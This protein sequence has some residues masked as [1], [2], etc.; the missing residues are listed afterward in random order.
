MEYGVLG[1][2]EVRDGE[3]LIALGSSQ[4]RAVLA[5]LLLEANRPVSLDRLV[6][7]LWGEQPPRSA[8]AVV[9]N[10][11]S[12]LRK[13][14]AP[15]ELRTEPSGYLLRVE[16]DQLD[17]H[18]FEQLAREGREALTIGRS[19]WAATLLTQAL[20]LWRGPALADF[21]YEAFAQGEIARLEELRLGALEN[22]LDADLACGRAAELVP[23]L[24]ALVEQHPLRERVRGQLVLALYR[25][26]RQ[27][28]AL[29][30]YQAARQ[31]LVEELGVDPSPELQALYKGVLTQDDALAAPLPARHASRLPTPPTPRI[32][33]G[34]EL[35]ELGGILRRDNVRLL[36]LVGP[37]GTGKTRLGIALAAEAEADY[38]QRAAFVP[39]A[40][41]EDATLVPSAIARELGVQELTDEEP[42]ETVARALRD[43]ELLLVLDNFEQ[44]VEA[45]TV[46]SRVLEAA[47]R[48]KIVVTSRLPLRITGE[49]EY[50]VPPLA[51][52]DAASLFGARALA[53][54]PGFDPEA[55]AASIS[56]ICGRLDGLPLAI[57]LAAAR[58]KLLP[59]Q[60][61]LDR[62]GTGLDLLRARGDDVPQRQRTLRAAIDWSHGLLGE[63][64]AEIFRRLSVFSG[65]WTIEAAEAVGGDAE[66]DVPERIESLLDHSLVRRTRDDD[67]ERRFAMLRTIRDYAREKLDAAGEAEATHLLHATWSATVAT[68]AGATLRDSGLE[69][70]R[71]LARLEREH[72]NFRVALSW[73]HEH[74]QNELLS[75]LCA[76]LWLFWYMHNHAREGAR[77]LEIAVALPASQ[78]SKVRAHL[79]EGASVFA[80]LHGDLPRAERLTEESLA[81]YQELGD[82]QGTA[83][84][85][86]DSGVAAARRRDFAAASAYYEE[87]AA[88]FRE[89]GDRRALAIVISNLGDLALRKGDSVSAKAFG[90]ESLAL[91]RE[92]GTTFDIV[93]SLQNLA[94]AAL[95]EG[96]VENARPWLE[97]SL[98][99][100]HDLEATWNIGYAFEGLGAVVAA[101]AEWER[102]ARLLGR[103]EAIRVSTGAELETSEHIIH[104]RTLA[105]LRDHLSEH[106]LAAVMSAGSSLTD[107]EAI[108]LALSATSSNAV[109]IRCGAGCSSIRWA[110][111]RPSRPAVS[112]RSGDTR[113]SSIVPWSSSPDGG[114][115]RP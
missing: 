96:D 51:E 105:V 100:A 25:S 10:R 11:V 20:S 110:A 31:T 30:T 27:A 68:N 26:G 91:Q 22:R 114:A 29:E 16:P 39:L 41:L 50:P 38:A 43:Q 12:Q 90:S 54:D 92:I 82:R 44:V 99:L 53:I 87:S 47:P 106:E 115:T 103:A 21:A 102:A 6:E 3:R 45:A 79:L 34:R 64:D 73:T 93:I 84:L 62:L 104:E 5:A 83:F 70:G 113:R 56:E 57:E 85:L 97:E 19:A 48:L 42:V 65:G 69:L 60:A 71:A 8:T 18:R 49:H 61:L 75:R 63:P 74:G 80:G 17:L 13:L 2:L 36:T 46:V 1:P 89:L 33:R 94:T 14:L 52:A 77:W 66:N 32:G 67:A 111:T 108:G 98:L 28:D 4:Q 24:E 78:P 109:L 23:E 55:S 88:L 15:A 95:H 81:M 112:S 37:G 101:Q 59:P 9:K 40:T 86:R 76:G 7:A 58:V 35:E 72:D 107:D